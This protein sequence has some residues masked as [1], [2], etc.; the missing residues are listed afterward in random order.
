L[1]KQ[2]VP[3]N[4]ADRGWAYV[5][6]AALP[7]VKQEDVQVLVHGHTLTIRSRDAGAEGSE[8]NGANGA[9]GANR[10]KDGSGSDEWLVHEHSPEHWERS[11]N[12]P[13]EVDESAISAEYKD[14]ILE[15]LL[16][17]AEPQ[18]ERR[19]PVRSGS[20]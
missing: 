13:H 7:G 15:L 17:K 1:E 3:L 18:A 9:N 16:P 12:L 4:I 6:R 10:A 8:S 19:I 5:V 2:D 20:E 14:G 11:L